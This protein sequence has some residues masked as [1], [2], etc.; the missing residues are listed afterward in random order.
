MVAA[1]VLADGY[2]TSTG[3]LVFI[4]REQLIWGSG[5]PVQGFTVAVLNPV[6]G[7]VVQL[8]GRAEFGTST[9]AR[10]YARAILRGIDPPVLLRGELLR[11]KRVE[12]TMATYYDRANGNPYVA[13]ALVID[14]DCRLR[15]SMTYGGGEDALGKLNNVIG[16]GRWWRLTEDALRAR[17]IS[18]SVDRTEFTRGRELR[19][20]SERLPRVHSL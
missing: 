13:W 1:K 16:L 3:E 10:R 11:A 6:Y 9:Q 2:E 18:L 17:G 5:L 20:Y 4:V 7:T 15:Q 8:S 14:G 19:A 12:V